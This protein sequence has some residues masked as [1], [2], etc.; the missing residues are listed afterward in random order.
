MAAQR[1]HFLLLGCEQV[2]QQGG[3]SRRLEDTCHMPVTGAEPTASTAVGEQYD[4]GR[5][6]RHREISLKRCT[7]GRNLNGALLCVRRWYRHRLL[8]SRLTTRPSDMSQAN[9]PPPSRPFAPTVRLRVSG[10][11]G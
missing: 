9:R 5:I 4:T 7:T 1:V 11:S 8:T 10:R 2:H 3:E 6:M